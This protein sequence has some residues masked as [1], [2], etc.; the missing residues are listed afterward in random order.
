MDI[1]NKN[2]TTEGGLEKPTRH[3]IDWKSPDFLNEEKYEQELRRVADACHGCRRC[4]SLCNSFPS[5]F[6]LIDN[7]ETFEV[8]GVAYEQFSSVVDHCYLCDLCFMTKCPYVP[9]H[10][11]EIDFPHL[12]LRGKAIK[13]SKKKTSLRDKILSSTDMLGR[14]FSRPLI[15]SLANFFN[16]LKLFRK[17]L[18]LFG[19]HQNAKLPKFVSKTA[20]KFGLMNHVDNALYKV[21]IYTTCYHNYNEPGVIKD[22]YDIL[23]HNN[24]TVDIISQDNCCGMPKLELGNIAKVEQM[25]KNNLPQFKKYVEQ[26]YLIIAPIPSCV[27]MYKQELPLLFPD[28]QDLI[29]VSQS[30][31]DPFEF[32]NMLNDEGILNKDFKTKLGNVSY[33]VAC[34]QRVQNFGMLTKKILELIP[35]TKVDA[36]ERCSGH[37]GTYGVKS[38][39]H[40]IAI[41]IAKPITKAFKDANFD[42]FTSDCSLAAHHIENSLGNIQAPEH[43]ISLI[44]KA[45]GI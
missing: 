11:W 45:Y 29:N 2:T 9:P 4:V 20:K 24:V 37:D 12:M 43:P 23:K 40:D 19:I 41:K 31:R 16:N 27:L 13:D 36:L 38:E 17:L 44:K 39:T 35:G 26:G 8:D 3:I 18:T 25:M 30:F 10:E 32:L 7:S 28:N 6:D 42:S 34:H 1:T 22:F 5:L 15:S 33:Q 14:L 21:A